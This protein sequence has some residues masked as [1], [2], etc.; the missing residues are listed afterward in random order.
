MA[1]DTRVY[2]TRM[3][4]RPD[5]IDLFRHVHSS[6]YIDYVLAA[7]F[8]QMKTCYGMPM[9]EFLEHGLG[10]YMTGTELHFK[11]ALGMGDTFDV[12]THIKEMTG[13]NVLV[14]FDIKFAGN[15]KSSCTGWAK[16]ALVD[17]KTGKTIEIPQW[18]IDRYSMT[19]DNS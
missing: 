9:E 7:R 11:R 19:E 5:D 8:E 4:V 6:R 14:H 18:V 13:R 17:L 1:L 12:E 16:Y 15:G 10:W 2:S 3:S